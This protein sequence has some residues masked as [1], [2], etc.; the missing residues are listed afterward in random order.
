MN[1]NQIERRLE[2]L[3]ESIAPPNTPRCQI[4]I[5]LFGRGEDGKPV[6]TG[7][8]IIEIPAQKSES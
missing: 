7:E 5:L 2:R 3:E 1:N 6:H 4:R 8:R